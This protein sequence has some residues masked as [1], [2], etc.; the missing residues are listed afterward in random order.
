LPGQNGLGNAPVV[1]ALLG[2]LLDER[3]Q[4]ASARDDRF[5]GPF[6]LEQRA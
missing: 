2:I 4:R 6:R 5:V 3:L 1:L